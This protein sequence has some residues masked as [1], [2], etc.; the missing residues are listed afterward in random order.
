MKKLAM[1]AVVVL[2]ALP[3]PVTLAPLLLWLWW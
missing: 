2:W 1:A 3:G